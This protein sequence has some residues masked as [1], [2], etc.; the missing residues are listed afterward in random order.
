MKE[1]QIPYVYR[2]H[3]CLHNHVTSTCTNCCITVL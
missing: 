3:Y 2:Y 1:L